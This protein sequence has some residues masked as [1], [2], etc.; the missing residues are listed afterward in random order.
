[1]KP[2]SVATISVISILIVVLLS[3]VNQGSTL[4]P[5]PADLNTG[6]YVDKLVYKV[7]AN[8]AQRILALQNG[9]IEMDCSS[10][11]SMY[12]D[13]L[14][15]DPDIDIFG[16][17]RNGYGQITINCRDAPLN[18]TSLRRAFAYAFDK[19][20]ETVEIMDGY[21]Q[22]HDSVVPY[23]NGWCVEDEFTFHYYTNQSEIGNRLLNQSG[24]FEYDGAGEYRTYKGQPFDITIE[25][26]ASSPEIASGTAQIGVDALRS[27]GIDAQT[28]ASDFN[29]FINRLDS[30]GDYDMVFYAQNFYDNDIDWLAYEFWSEYAVVPCQNPTNFKN[31]SYDG[32]RDQLLHGTTYVEVYEAASEMQNILHY[33][34]PK[35]IVYEDVYFQGYRNDVFTGHVEDLGRYIS[36]P[37]TMRKIHKLDS[38]P[39]GTVPIAI[40]QE[41][42]SFNIF[43]T[44]SA[45]SDAILSNLYS[46][47]Y[48][49]GPD[50][51]PWPD[52]A[53]SMT[54]ETHADN[55]AVP[56]GYT[57]FTIDIIQN[58]YWSDGQPLTADDVA[59]T[60]VYMI[61]SGVYGNP[62][63]AHLSELVAAYAPTQFE[64][65]IE[66]NTESNWH[67]SNF[68]YDYIIPKHIF[69]NT[70]GIGYSGWNSWNPV[71][72][73]SEPHVTSGPFN[74]TDY[75]AGEF[76]ELTK[77]PNYYYA[78]D[79]TST[80]T[81]STTS[82]ST[83]TTTSN[84]PPVVLA[85][86]G[87][88]YY[89]GTTG[90]IIYWSLYDDNP[91]LY[92]V[93]LDDIQNDTGTW[94]GSDISINV[95][96]LP[97]GRHNYTLYLMDNSAN[98]V[99]ST[100]FVNVLTRPSTTGTPDT[101]TDT[102]TTISSSPSTATGTTTTGEEILDTIILFVSIGSL[103]V[104]VVVVIM[105]VKSNK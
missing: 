91:L 19:T 58:A 97:V 23:P 45:Y 17:L 39:G 74:F 37:W 14:T 105:I 57:R 68:A 84:P 42:D 46:S 32:W 13:T 31:A 69:N 7:I 59:F 71:F 56:D 81:T 36:G 72:D 63:G 90:H 62:A 53:E 38:T 89:E 40:A 85:S 18:E 12:L 88:T 103:G 64:V 29:E 83:A 51:N 101:T 3:N 86:S 80:I 26:A 15:A 100:V 82:T 43:T 95:D 52:L 49:Y 76:Y 98:V 94:N 61:E 78:P 21:S 73:S 65:V 79:V 9:M 24:K 77:N 47:L 99:V 10:V 67:F 75:E 54:V 104:I 33:N 102:T 20:R 28:Q 2:K 93:Y 5:I 4:D 41:P 92:K 22:E 70:G 6:P 66:F 27:L 30:H 35:L 55:G 16:N 44:N 1:M 96:G 8:E 50:L 48:K 87:S 11:N 60:F 34:V 25:Y